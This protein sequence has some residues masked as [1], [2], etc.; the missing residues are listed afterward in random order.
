MRFAGL[1]LA[2]VCALT[3]FTGID[4]PGL[5]DWREARDAQVAR[6]MIARQ[7]VLTPLYGDAFHFEKPAPAYAPEALVQWLASD[8]VT[9]SRRVRAVFAIL[10]LVL[11][12]SIGAQMF[13]ARAGVL[14]ALVL[15]TA[16]LLPLSVRTDG[17]Q[18]LA[19]L[20]A[21]VGVAGLADAQFMRRAGRALR[22]VVAW[23]ALTATLVIAGPLPALWPVAG[24]ALYLALARDGEGWRRVALP[25]GLVLMIGVALP[26]YGAMYE[27]HGA[28]FLAHAAFF[29]YAAE[30]R[31]AWWSGPLLTL[32]FLVVGFFPWSALLPGAVTH[33][34][35]WWHRALR[36][37]VLRTGG[38]RHDPIARE[39]REEGAA[40]FF[41]A[42]ML[43]ALVP[44]ALYPGPPLTAALPALPA[45]ALLCGRLLDHA[46]EDAARL[47][48]PLRNAVWMMALVGSVGAVLV[49]MVGPRIPEAAPDLRLVAT[50]VFVTSWIPVLI[51]L[52]GRRAVAA[53]TLALPVTIGT[54][55]VQSRLLPAL[56]GWLNT[57]AV[58]E[59]MGHVAPLEARLVLIEPPRP[60]LRWYL[61]RNLVVADDLGAAVAR[62]RADDGLTYIAFRPYR[63]SAVASGAGG[64]MEIVLRT[65]TLVLA[66]VHAVGE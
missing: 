10:L 60:S 58:A 49:A 3:L 40:H 56:E 19:T 37:T 65:P 24:W 55:V 43:A 22:L 32:S 50:L 45:A 64:V 11:T 42:C 8:P 31:G 57:R 53:L 26:W 17:T 47:R 63:E 5:F 27:R 46:F 30:T 6:E 38:D 59:A 12:G 25:A 36:M 48:A 20:L 35:T 9:M 62:E 14:A 33:A 54:P 23:G 1:A 18:L 41:V 39:V 21:W 44:V 66:R 29:P 61:A 34:A 28:A 13:G 15:A 2:A 52:T 7:E 51:Y 16:L 4:R